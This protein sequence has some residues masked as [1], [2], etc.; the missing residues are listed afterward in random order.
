MNEQAWTDD[1]A[2]RI[3]ARIAQARNDR[4]WSLQQ[5]ADRVAAVAGKDDVTRA[6][7]GH[8]ETGA[9]TVKLRDLWAL[10]RVLGVSADELLFGVQRWPFP[11]LSYAKVMDLEPEDRN[12]IEGGIL[13]LATELGVDVRAPRSDSAKARGLTPAGLVSMVEAELSSAAPQPRMRRSD[14]ASRDEASAARARKSKA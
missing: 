12:R 9:R 1:Q 4:G 8:W 13:V 3:G 14:D 5:L 7:A 11:Q 10:C 2:A 6:T